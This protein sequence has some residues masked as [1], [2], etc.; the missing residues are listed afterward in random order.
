ML[1]PADLKDISRTA[2]GLLQDC[3]YIYI[4]IYICMSLSLSLYIY[5]YIHIPQ[6]S[7][8]E[9]MEVRESARVV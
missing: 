2:R 1:K 8:R 9:S 3:I 6:G 7:N 4:Y 5:I